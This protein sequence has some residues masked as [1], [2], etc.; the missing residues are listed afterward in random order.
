[1]YETIVRNLE[2]QGISPSVVS[3]EFLYAPYYRV[4]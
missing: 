4:D 3:V 1:M 2:E